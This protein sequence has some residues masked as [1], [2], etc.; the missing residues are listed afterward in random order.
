VSGPTGTYRLQL[1]AGFTLD[2]AA[3]VLPY[4]AD[5][6]VSHVYL[7]PILQ[8]TPG[9]QHGYDVVDHTRL[10]DD[11]GGAEGFARFDAAARAAG[12]GVV[13]DVVPNHMAVPRPESLNAP[14]WSVLRDGSDSPY[15]A[16]YDVDW[17]SRRP[18]L[19]PVLGKR[20]G[21]A[22]TD[23][24]LV[25]DR[26]GPEPVLRYADH[27]FPIKPGTADLPL[28]EL[29]DTQWYRLAHWVVAA[30]ELNYRRFFDVDTLVAVRV[31]DPQV[32]HATHALLAGLYAQG[33]VSGLRIDHP[34]GLADPRGYL[35]MLAEA[36]PGAWVV[37]EK[38]LEGHEQLPPDWQ[39]AGT[40][41]YD[42]LNRCLGLLIDGSGAEP[43]TWLWG[44][45]A[46]EQEREFA[47][48]AEQSK[49]YVLA[50]SL[51]AE[52]NRLADL[53]ARISD[54][55]VLLRDLT[56]RGLQQG[57]EELLVAMPVYRAYVRP[58][59]PAPPES[60]TMLERAAERA[61]RARPDRADEIALL[62]DL[63]LGRLGS[64]G[65][66]R[67]DEFC[68]RFQQT[69]GPVMAKGIEDTAFYRWHRL[70]ALN[71]VGGDPATFGVPPDA[72]HA[73]ADQQAAR[74][75]MGMTTLSTHDTKRSEDVRAR[76]AVLSEDP[77]A[78]RAALEEWRTAASGMRSRDGWP[79]PA[80]EYLVW[81]TLVGTWPIT[82]DRL[83]GF[84]AKAT[85]EAKLHTSWTS[86]DPVYDEAVESYARSV[87]ADDALR[88]SLAQFVE[89]LDGAF[90]SNLLAQ[91]LVQLTMP[92]V[93][94][95]YQGCDLVDLSLV[96][97]DNRRPIN[98]PERAERLRR[99]DA[100]DRPRDVH[101]TK[102]LVTS[103]ALRLRRR[104]PEPFRGEYTP[105]P[106]STQHA[107][108][109]L[110]GTEVA[111]V[112][113]RLPAALH[114][115]GGWTEDA[116][117]VLPAGR[118]CEELTGRTVPGGSVRCADLFAELPVALLTAVPVPA[119][120]EG[121]T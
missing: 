23:G 115:H 66:G 71:E 7:S 93:P 74:W 41:G 91:K 25:V 46:S 86:P 87:L 70:V 10:S 26:S 118:W 2:D 107:F 75:P 80:T 101:D 116:S 73:W 99:L 120:E 76:L 37:V 13:V 4:L 5:L 81:Q 20:I 100:G 95:V 112:V 64:G 72:V 39:C 35:A 90:T 38:I 89:S 96:D 62:R 3:A 47:D 63:A 14:L 29:V 92:G 61:T 6:G 32:F 19:M 55:D 17:E 69:C 21:R 48:V 18:M 8:A 31:E 113:T 109:F 102:L 88:E 65:S 22:L 60:V 98:F 42:A 68:V 43:L 24:D 117:V 57:L 33:A 12:L 16:W 111:V 53:A 119:A 105:L 106:T 34:D 44:G 27:V 50:H 1:Q 82:P 84:L 104:H 114:R 56:R 28:P 36:F 103:R 15:A 11:L 110:R 121:A 59:E 54:D 67:R 51:R 94:D 108:G 52:V 9:S 85:R 30:E 40:T 79:E 45:L 77:A 78:W 83:V 49:R 58:G 97:P